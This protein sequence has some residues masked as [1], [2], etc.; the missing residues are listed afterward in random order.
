MPFEVIIEFFERK[1]GDLD[2]QSE[3]ELDLEY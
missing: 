1:N 3:S 2:M